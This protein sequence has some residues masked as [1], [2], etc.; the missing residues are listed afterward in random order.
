MSISKVLEKLN[1]YFSLSEKKRKKKEVEL[2]EI[3]AKLEKKKSKLKK[4]LKA[5]KIKDEKELI[6]IELEA[7]NKL[8]KKSQKLTKE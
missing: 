6:E 3:V 1:N 5:S 4:A 7:V 2:R 8:L